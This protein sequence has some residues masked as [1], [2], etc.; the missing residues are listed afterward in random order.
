MKPNRIDAALLILRSSL[1]VMWIAHAGLKF[2][3]FTIAGFA[4]WLSSQGIPAWFAWPVFLTEFLGGICILFGFRG[5]QASLML[6]P[7]LAVA[8]LI[9]ANN[10][11]VHTSS[12]GGW[13]YPLFLLLMSIVHGLLGDGRYAV[14][15]FATSDV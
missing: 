2:F 3:V 9:H 1:G 8:T 15:T 13:E 5:N 11:W 14:R 10:G 12:G 6:V 7:V 4:A